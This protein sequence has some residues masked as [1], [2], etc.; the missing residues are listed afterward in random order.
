MTRAE[1]GAVAHVEV[2]RC[3][4]EAGDEVT[5]RSAGEYLPKRDSGVRSAKLG[6]QRIS[7]S[8]LDRSRMYLNPINRLIG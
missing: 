7:G 5:S 3:V 2:R 6:L 1:V 8:L 4:A